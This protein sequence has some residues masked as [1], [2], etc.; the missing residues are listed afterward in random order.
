MIT[1]MHQIS[2]LD[3]VEHEQFYLIKIHIVSKKL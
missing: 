3:I 1:N 2:T